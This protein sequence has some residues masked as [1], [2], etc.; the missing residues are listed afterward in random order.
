MHG[1]EAWP[2]HAFMDLVKHTCMDLRPGWKHAFEACNHAPGMHRHHCAMV[3]K[4]NEKEIWHFSKNWQNLQALGHR[5]KN[6]WRWS[7][8]ITLSVRCVSGSWTVPEARLDRLIDRSLYTRLIQRRSGAV[9]FRLR[10][11]IPTL[12]SL[13]C[14]KEEKEPLLKDY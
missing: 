13:Y 10:P 4:H 5:K 9:R 2:E 3:L 7:S 11:A 6:W 1:S 14:L 8:I 12:A